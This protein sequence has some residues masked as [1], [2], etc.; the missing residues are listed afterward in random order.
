ME[1]QNWFKNF[2]KGNKSKKKRIIQLVLGFFILFLGIAGIWFYSIFQ[3]D[4]NDLPKIY[5][6]SPGAI[7]FKDKSSAYFSYISND[8]EIDHIYFQKIRI[9]ARGGSTEN[10]PK[11]NFTI[12]LSSNHSLG[13][14]EQEDDWILN[15]SFLDKSFIRHALSFQLFRS[16]DKKHKAPGCRY[17]EVYRNFR[18]QGLYVLMER[19][20][21]DRLEINT[22]DKSA[23]L[24][25]EPP[26]F[27]DPK[28]FVNSNPYKK[29]DAYH[30]KFPKLE[31]LNK[32]KDIEKLRNFIA[33]SPDSLF[34]EKIGFYFD[35]DNIMDWHLLLLFTN[36]GDGLVKNFYLYK[37]DRETAFRVVP[38]DYDHTFGRDGDNE[39]NKQEIMKIDRN[40]LL[41]RLVSLN[42]DGY[43]ERLKNRYNE[44]KKS[45]KLSTK[46]L[47]KQIDQEY[48]RIHD[49]AKKNE[50]RWPVKAVYFF[51][52]ANFENEIRSIK[53]WIPIQLKLMDDYF[54]SF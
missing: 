43:L 1:E 32:S 51:D 49:F 22:S 47:V 16:F 24:F 6:Y 45:G 10:L 34:N 41:S 35:M 20:D 9:K 27:V 31:E 14:L 30:Q 18:Y 46:M 50:D 37:K 42:T 53:K 54:D 7:P 38:W 15:A 11:Q 21:K 17:V 19:M 4:S 44:L 25:K 48:T 52:D 29:N 39:P 26:V 36:N 13:G 5:L 33:N 3:V 8:P 2:L 23:C 12:E 40:T 28:Y